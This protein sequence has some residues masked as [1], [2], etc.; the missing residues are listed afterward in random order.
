M[1]GVNCTIAVDFTG[2]VEQF[3]LWYGP[4]LVVLFV[5]TIGVFVIAFKLALGSRGKGTEGSAFLVAGEQYK[6]A[7]S[8]MLPLLAY[9]VIFCTLIVPPFIYRVYGALG[10]TPGFG[11]LAV[12]WLCFP[13]W[14]LAA[15]VALVAHVAV[16]A[17]HRRLRAKRTDRRTNVV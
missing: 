9:P 1:A 4:A 8:Q 3:A 12:A 14:S 2:V 13:G 7:L 11:L 16:V 17:R 15:S 10:A 5:E 6:K